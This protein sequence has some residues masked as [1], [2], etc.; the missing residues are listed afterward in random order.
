MAREIASFQFQCGVG[1]TGNVGWQN[2]LDQPF[3]ILLPVST[4]VLI[5][6]VW[7]GVMQGYEQSGATANDSVIRPWYN[8]RMILQKDSI[9]YPTTGAI[10]N[11]NPLVK[12]N[13]SLVRTTDAIF[14]ADHDNKN[15]LVDIIGNGFRID[16]L[17]FYVQATAPSV[18]AL[19]RFHFTIAYRVLCAI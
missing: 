3:T 14:T 8:V 13:N 2:V 9:D 5:E 15:F 19:I 17:G 16:Q 11:S 7:T 6:Q 4:N 18:N 1:S 12:T 10:V